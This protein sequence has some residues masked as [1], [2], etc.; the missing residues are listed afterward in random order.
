MKKIYRFL[1]KLLIKTRIK[2][3]PY[4]PNIHQTAEVGYDVLVVDPESLI[5]EEHT[6]INR[7][8]VIMNGKN[9]QFIM[10]KHSGAAVGLLAICGNH[11]SAV[12]KNIKDIDDSLKKTMDKHGDYSK[13][14]TVHEDVWIGARVTL[15]QGVNLGRGS[16]IG[17]GSVV[18]T[19]VPPYAIVV[20]NPAKIIGFR[21]SPDEILEH[22]RI[23]YSENDRLQENLIR[24]NYKKYFL[25]RVKEIK[26]FTKLSL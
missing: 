4:Y 15:L 1:N 11:M 8:A 13:T 10:K 18:R 17:A 9:G 25:S 19:D 21:F 24:N 22:E 6:N 5:M 12:G 23:L 16:I 20:G 2:A 26:D 7:G 3:N 14:I